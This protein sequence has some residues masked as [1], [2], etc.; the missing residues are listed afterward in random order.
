MR[1]CI[2]VHALVYAF[3]GVIIIIIIER[4]DGGF[5][6]GQQQLQVGIPIPTEYACTH[7]NNNII[8]Y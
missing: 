2:R 5:S 8:I 4:A 7:Y 3:V 6:S 1:V